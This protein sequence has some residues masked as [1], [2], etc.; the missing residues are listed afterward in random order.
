MRKN[1][2]VTNEKCVI[3]VVIHLAINQK[4]ESCE[5]TAI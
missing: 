5:M 1:G 4:K 3:G 2:F